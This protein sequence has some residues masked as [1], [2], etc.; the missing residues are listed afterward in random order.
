M[1]RMLGV[2]CSLPRF[3]RFR[4]QLHDS[5]SA[6]ALVLVI[7]LSVL[8]PGVASAAIVEAETSLVGTWQAEV[9]REGATNAAILEFSE[10]GKVCLSTHTSEGVGA[11]NQTTQH[12]SYT[13]KENL[14]NGYVDIN[15]IGRQ[16]RDNRF[17]SAGV[18]VVY[19]STG[20]RIG[21]VVSVVVA[22]RLSADT[23]N[24]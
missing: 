3:A 10:S 15:Q 2:L 18:S 6:R 1:M 20:K 5:R 24:C 19:D 13:V 22:T 14:P 16:Y 21:K 11:W 4:G 17:T 8:A 7:M 9:Y 23:T 12:L